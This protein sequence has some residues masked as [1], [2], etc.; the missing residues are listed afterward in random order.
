[1]TTTSPG[2]ASDFAGAPRSK[3]AR[4]LR[5]ADRARARTPVLTALLKVFL[6]LLALSRYEPTSLVFRGT[7]AV[8]FFGWFWRS[9]WLGGV[10]PIDVCLAGII[11]AAWF[12]GR[13][14][15][16]APD[17]LLPL[18]TVLLAAGV[19][20]RLASRTP[21]DTSQDLL[22]QL[23]NYA[24]LGGI[25][26]AATRVDWSE[27]QFRSMLGWIVLLAAITLLLSFAEGLYLPAE[28]RVSKYGR[29]VSL[30]D[31]ADYP[32]VLLAQ[33]W[34]IGLALERV[35]R[36]LSTR[37]ALAIAIAY[38]LYSA[39]TGI[40]K[41][42]LFLYPVFLAYFAWSYRLYRRPWFA[43]SA[44]FFALA[45]AGLA[46][47]LVVQRPRIEET[48]PL[49]VYATFTS[50]DQSVSTRKMELVNFVE[51]MRNR[52][53]WLQGIGIGTKWREY[54][55][56]PLD[57]AAFPPQ[58]QGLGWHLG[59]H[60]P[61]LRLAYDFGVVG[62][63]LLVAFGLSR[64]RGSRRQTKRTPLH[65]MTRA[66][67]HAAW[68]TI[69]YQVAVNN[70]SG[71]KTNLFAGILLAALAGLPR[72]LIAFAHGPRKIPATPLP[73]RA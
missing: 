54:Q 26:F 66:F 51:N 11:V 30:R 68:L 42:V 12:S 45:L 56:Q 62:S 39:F 35:P 14:P 2:E 24:Y 52:G 17:F 41:A 34:L 37:L 57:L 36:R 73:V 22:F 46:A 16:T 15:R 32:F 28:S 44:S 69:A 10:S 59:V 72:S 8:D 9:R 18:L 29:F 5:R 19:V 53:A 27:R 58:E 7:E 47:Y 31:V 71:P 48:S 43:I 21:V 38:T 70:L 23:R 20:V 25:Y 40:G 6:L 55:E 65:P 49:Y 61:F 3:T 1:M 4:P 67:I 13:R 63:G 33:L 64:F 60:V 50:E